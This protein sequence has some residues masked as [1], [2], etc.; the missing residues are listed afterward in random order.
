MNKLL[1]KKDLS[2]R[3]QITPQTVD[4]YIRDGIITPVKGIPSIRF[5]EQHISELEGLKMER[6]SPIQK[7]KLEKELEEWKLRAE[8]AE[9]ALAH[10][11]MILTEALYMKQVSE[12]KV[13]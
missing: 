6:F 7:R 11:N 3:W 5:T 2:A 13:I 8:E 1:T 9:K 4:V 12:R 10:A